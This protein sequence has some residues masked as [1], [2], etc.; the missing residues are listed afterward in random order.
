MG[1]FYKGIE[2]VIEDDEVVLN[3]NMEEMIDQL[4]QGQFGID[5][6]FTEY[7]KNKEDT[8]LFASIVKKAIEFLEQKYG[9]AEDTAERLYN[10]HRELISYAEKL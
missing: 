9:I 3:K 6:D 1:T 4:W 10:F 2:E 7:L 8:M 5:F